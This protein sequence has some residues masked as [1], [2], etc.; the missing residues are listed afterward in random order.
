M[1]IAASE[2]SKN[3]EHYL[4]NETKS[5]DSHISISETSKHI[6]EIS[7][8]N[9]EKFMKSDPMKKSNMMY[10]KTR[11]TTYLC[12]YEGKKVIM[13]HSEDKLINKNFLNRMFTSNLDLFVQP[14]TYSF[15]H[16]F[17]IMPYYKN[18]SIHDYL[19]DK[20]IKID[21]EKRIKYI[22][23][24]LEA[25][26]E[27]HN[28]HKNPI[29]N[30]LTRNIFLDDEN[31]IKIKY[32]S[33]SDIYLNEDELSEFN[34]N[35]EQNMNTIAPEL[36]KEKAIH[37]IE[38]D[39][40]SIGCI[41][42]EI[43]S[44]KEIFDDFTE[45][46]ITS[47]I[48]DKKMK[49]CIPDDDDIPAELIELMYECLDYDPQKRPSINEIIERLKKI[50][51]SYLQKTSDKTSDESTDTKTDVKTVTG[52][53][54]ISPED[55]QRFMK[56]DPMNESNILHRNDKI[57]TYISEYNGKKVTVIQLISSD[58]SEYFLKAPF[59]FMSD[60][61]L[62]AKPITYSKSHEF[63]MLPY[64]KNNSIDDY[65]SDEKNVIDLN[66]CIEYALDTS[67][68]LKEFHNVCKKPIYYLNT[69][70]IF[71]DDDR[72]IKIMYTRLTDTASND[73]YL[74][75]LG[76]FTNPTSIYINQK[77][78]IFAP[79]LFDHDVHIP[80][81][82]TDIHSFGCVIFQLLTRRNPFSGVTLLQFYKILSK[83]EKIV[84]VPVIKDVPEDFIQLVYDCMNNDPEKRPP[85]DEIINRL[86][87]M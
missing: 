27:Y 50:L 74:K 15:T 5:Y 13:L 25:I 70:N 82:K 47:L 8:E 38:S 44:R 9:L 30:A 86:N 26:Q 31:K 73:K 85:I 54:E 37:T 67:K 77:K 32:I 87:A 29:K 23:D 4:D 52:L 16:N 39:V 62:F 10:K 72:K 3:T 1:G 53:C 84:C 36:Y 81:F 45:L 18:K 68:A 51:E 34:I 33:S 11:A 41:I 6:S 58:T 64:Y 78:N 12:E 22:I 63:I 61:N 19:S 28:I 56:Q 20:K 49:R 71:L 14:I 66:K 40:H 17:V 79:E 21:V 2:F 69:R 59:T 48:L 65:I 35:N 43:I 75:E 55:L 46:C 80:T 7:P 42:F 24:I 60:L 57:T 76:S 83:K